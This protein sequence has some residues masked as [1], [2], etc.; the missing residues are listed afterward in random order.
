MDAKIIGTAGD[1]A[2]LRKKKSQQQE[3]SL[4][5]GAKKAQ[6]KQHLQK[7]ASSSAG[8]ATT[9]AN[10]SPVLSREAASAQAFDSVNFVSTFLASEIIQKAADELG[11][12]ARSGFGAF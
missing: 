4:D 1:G 5:P 8:A 12:V 7:Q 6:E 11:D 10:D 2:G 9:G 3:Q